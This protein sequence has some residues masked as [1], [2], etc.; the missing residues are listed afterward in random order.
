MEYYN[1][2]TLFDIDKIE[3]KPIR[4][5]YATNHLTR[6]RYARFALEIDLKRPLVSRIWVSNAWQMVEYENIH[7]LC[8][9]CGRIGNLKDKC[10]SLVNGP[11][12]ATN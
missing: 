12:V 1:K 7:L 6:A 8:F 4:V 5:D 11:I 2:H 10:T 9:K 3:G